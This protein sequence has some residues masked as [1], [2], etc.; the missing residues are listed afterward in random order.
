MTRLDRIFPV[1]NQSYEPI[2]DQ[3]HLSNSLTDTTAVR[4]RHSDKDVSNDDEVMSI[5][6]KRRI[7]AIVGIII[8]SIMFVILFKQSS[9]AIRLESVLERSIPFKQVVHPET[10]SPLWGNVVKPF[11]TGAFWTNFVVKNGDGVVG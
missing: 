6:K 5:N 9:R 2:V 4:I 1:G 8:S 11:P 10:P 3:S 7:N